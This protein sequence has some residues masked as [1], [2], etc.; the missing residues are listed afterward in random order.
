MKQVLGVLRGLGVLLGIWA[1]LFAVGLIA[2]V[3]PAVGGEGAASGR[4]ER[5]GEAHSDAQ[6][7]AAIARAE[8]DGGAATTAGA[9]ATT[10]AGA[11]EPRPTGETAAAA[12]AAASVTAQRFTVCDAGVRMP[13]LS[14]A[15]LVGSPVPELAVGC[16][17][18]VHV[19]AIEA[20]ESA[21]VPARV[22]TFEAQASDDAA[23]TMHAGPIASGDVD[24][25]SL[26]DVV[27]P[28]WQ[29]TTDGSARGGRVFLVRRE[30][31]GAFADPRLLGPI[32]AYDVAIA[33]LDARPGLDV[34]ALNRGSE[35]ARRPSEAW[36]FA[37]G[38]APVRTA[39][40]RGGLGGR[41]VAVARLD[42]DEHPDI[43]MATKDEPRV[44]VFYGDGTG[45]FPRS[46]TV[47]VS[48][49]TE[50]AVADLDADGADDVIV[51]GEGLHL[52]RGGGEDALVALPI[53]APRDLRDVHA[54]SADADERRDVVALSAGTVV[55]LRQTE[56]LAFAETRLFTVEGLAIHRLA[57]ADFTADGTLDAAVLVRGTG[58]TGPWELLLVRDLPSPKAATIAPDPTLLRDAPLVLTIPLR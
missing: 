38:P 25:D 40:L 19:I 44:D 31:S 27:V 29:S 5:E 46:S 16:G 34:V 21:L 54:V 2:G 41:A 11:A 50:L 51:R 36:V 20:S 13:E 1:I 18:I 48:G 22:V 37:G 52:I 12:P 35:L 39:V 6:P 57:V 9:T 4:V 53:D 45:R 8:A 58:E 55:A 3:I 28:F 17:G 47:A 49:A 15:Q 42:P 7:D 10:T 30:A 23:L 24:D 56:P 33:Q 26:T 43:V 14:V 32:A